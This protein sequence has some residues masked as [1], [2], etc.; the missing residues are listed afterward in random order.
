MKITILVNVEETKSPQIELAK[1]LR[2]IANDWMPEGEKCGFAL[3]E[4][5]HWYTLEGKRTRKL[6]LDGSASIAPVEL[7]VL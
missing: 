1:I 6:S 7:R 3:G 5:S 4:G 2:G